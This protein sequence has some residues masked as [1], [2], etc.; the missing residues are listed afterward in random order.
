MRLRAD[1]VLLRCAVWCGVHIRVWC[2]VHIQVWQHAL[3]CTCVSELSSVR[4]LLP[5]VVVCCVGGGGFV[6]CVHGRVECGA[7]CIFR[8]AFRCAA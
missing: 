3:A 8:C 7:V 4:G 5:H 2:G 1:G 6:E